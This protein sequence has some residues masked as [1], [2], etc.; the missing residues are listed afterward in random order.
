MQFVVFAL[1][2]MLVRMRGE[3]GQDLMEYALLSGLLAAALLAI[4]LVTQTFETGF[5]TMANGIVNC[6]DFDQTSTCNPPG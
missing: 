4:F 1:S 2:W 5:D 6:I 3:R